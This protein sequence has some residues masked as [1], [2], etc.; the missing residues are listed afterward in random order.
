[1]SYIHERKLG[2]KL[3]PKREA[4]GPGGAEVTVPSEKIFEMEK[5][6]RYEENTS[7]VQAIGDALRAKEDAE[8]SYMLIL[9]RYEKWIENRTRRLAKESQETPH[10]AE[11]LKTNYQREKE[12]LGV[13]VDRARSEFSSANA[14][15]RKL[16]DAEAKS[17]G[18]YERNRATTGPGPQ[19]PLYW[20]TYK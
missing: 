17:S 20:L 5:A 2:L 8:E 3:W 10:S 1:M 9:R 11:Y 16:A 15:Y 6:K 19:D 4:Y 7:V 18:R 13:E 14:N 12:K